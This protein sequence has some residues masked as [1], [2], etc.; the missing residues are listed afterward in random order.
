M[1]VIIIK[2][3]PLNIILNTTG[4]NIKFGKVSPIITVKKL[5]NAIKMI[6]GIPGN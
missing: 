6:Q 2:N 1:I 3:N 5:A 4:D